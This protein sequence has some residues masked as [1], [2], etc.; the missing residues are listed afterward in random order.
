M[1]YPLPL[2][3]EDNEKIA[4]TIKF[5]LEH[6]GYEAAL[7]YDGCAATDDSYHLIYLAIIMD[8]YTRI[9]RGWRLSPGL[10]VELTLGALEKALFR[11]SPQI[12]HSDQGVQY[13]A[14]NYTERL[15]S[16]GTKISMA[17]V[18]ESA[19]NGYAERVISSVAVTPASIGR[20]S[21]VFQFRVP[22]CPEGGQLFYFLG[23]LI[24]Q[25]GLFAYVFG[26]VVQM[27]ARR[28]C[29]STSLG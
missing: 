10:G 6:E 27:R 18:S 21:R 2:N 17:E 26:K 25:V 24:S 20:P 9:I 15:H 1:E 8:V 29:R 16:L 22:L 11:A 4:A 14:T 23:L 7:A 28:R 19:Q 5:Y 3:C 12:H 13:A